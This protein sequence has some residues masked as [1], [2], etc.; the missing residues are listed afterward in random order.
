[1]VGFLTNHKGAQGSLCSP[2]MPAKLAVKKTGFSSSSFDYYDWDNF[3]DAAALAPFGYRCKVPLWIPLDTTIEDQ[4]HARN[5]R[6][7]VYVFQYLALPF[8]IRRER[9]LNEFIILEVGSSGEDFALL[10]KILPDGTH[11]NLLQDLDLDEW[12]Y[13]NSK[14][15][16][17]EGLVPLVELPSAASHLHSASPTMGDMFG[18]QVY[19][20]PA[21]RIPRSFMGDTGPYEA[22]IT[23]YVRDQVLV[24][25]N[26]EQEGLDAFLLLWDSERKGF[27]TVVRRRSG[28]IFLVCRDMSSSLEAGVFRNEETGHTLCLKSDELPEM[29]G[30]EFEWS[31]YKKTITYGFR[32]NL[33]DLFEK[34]RSLSYY[35]SDF[36]RDEVLRPLGEDARHFEV[37][38][39][40]KSQLWI[41][42]EP[43][44]NGYQLADVDNDAQVALFTPLVQQHQRPLLV[45]F[46]CMAHF[47]T[48]CSDQYGYRLWVPREDAQRDLNEYVK[49]ALEG[50]GIR[51]KIWTNGK[52]GGDFTLVPMRNPKDYYAIL[53]I[54][55]NTNEN[56]QLFSIG[57]L[58]SNYAIYNERTNGTENKVTFDRLLD[59]TKGPKRLRSK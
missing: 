17:F 8:G 1:M 35:K 41:R 30:Q 58:G 46:A 32:F 42:K 28:A 13:T 52:D 40:A 34:G 20:P 50:M 7:R 49:Y 6:V 18:Y 39:F 26:G 24:A 44:V 19:L 59:L 47:E 33:P 51:C 31:S 22:G 57:R 43:T 5:M 36:I 54:H 45:Q 27:V 14:K 37:I 53:R 9:T 48:F 21:F 12:K 4:D 55:D 10:R 29:A 25:A 2:K 3:K 38:P 15:V 11:F 56:N 23:N 16:S